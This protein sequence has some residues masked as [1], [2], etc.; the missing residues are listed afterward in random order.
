MAPRRWMK[1]PDPD[2]GFVRA[3]IEGTR[4]RSWVGRYWNAVKHYVE[5]RGDGRLQQ[6]KGE[7]IIDAHGRRHEA[8]TDRQKIDQF[9]RRKQLPVDDIY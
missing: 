3:P 2:R 8:V 6:F 4:R 5:G 9:A 1:V 7:G